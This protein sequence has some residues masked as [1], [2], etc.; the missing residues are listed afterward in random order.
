MKRTLFTVLLISLFLAFL[1]PPGVAGI[2]DDIKSRGFIRAGVNPTLPGISFVDSKG[3]YT[4]FVIDFGKALSA[5]VG[6]ELKF[7]VVTSVDRFAALQSGEI[8]IHL[9]T[10]T[11]T[12]GRDT[13]VGVE[14]PGTY[15]FDGQGFLVRKSLGV[16]SGKDLDGATVCLASGTTSEGNAADYFRANNMS[17]KGVLFKKHDDCYRAY[18]QGRCDVMV[19]D[20]GQLACRRA[21]LKNPKDH[22]I[23]PDIIS[24]EPLGPM[25]PGGDNQWTDAVRWVVFAIFF[26]D[27]KGIT[28][29]NVEEVA[30]TTTNPEIQ[31]VL[32]VTASL[33]PDAG[34]DK[35]WAFRAIKAVGNFG[36]IWDRHLGLNTPVGLERDLNKQWTDGG[37]LYAPPFR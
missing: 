27:E 11:W 32:G 36:E 4:G 29:A 33:G 5:A 25:V 10:N 20:R 21:A 16:K 22:I 19:G 12:M 7:K 34:L 2:L 30:K 3:N 35:K 26:A 24:K 13:K 1:A 18:D 15:F 14:F 8:D 23:L 28:Q 9:A 17:Y 37:L 6:V 31:R